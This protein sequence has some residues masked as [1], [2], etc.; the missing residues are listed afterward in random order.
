MAEA[1]SLLE[2]IRFGYGPF[3]GQLFGVGGVDPD[4]VLA[5]LHDQDPAGAAWAQPDLAERFRL[6]TLSKGKKSAANPEKTAAAERL[7]VVYARD[8]LAF[9]ARP[10]ATRLGFPERLVNLWANRLTVANT[11]GVGT[12][13]MPFR[14]GAVRPHVA[15]RF[16]D[17]LKAALWHPAMLLYLNQTA[18][19][20]PNSSLGLRKGR[21]LNENLAR[22]FLELH[23]M[24]TGYDQS[25]VTE[26]ARLMAGMVTDA[27]G[28]RVDPRAAEPGV[29]VILGERY[30]DDDPAAEI[31]RL[32]EFVAARPETARSVG[33]ML[34]RH[35]VADVPPDDLVQAL[36][37]AY[38][39]N[40]GALPPV[41]RVLLTHPDA[42]SNERRK[43]RSPQEFVAAGLRAVNLSGQEKGLPGMHKRGMQLPMVV[44]HMGQP[45]FRAR[46]P[47]GWPE[48]AEGW[49]TPPMMA[50][51]LD[52]A[53]DL[54]RAAGEGSDPSA[55][56]EQVLGDLANPLLHQVVAGAEQR[57]EGLALLLGSPDFMRR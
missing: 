40:D 44:A 5:Q 38:R 10:A 20:G 51:R 53:I 18:S 11:A 25:D 36:A 31:D 22:E 48:V 46:R 35:F 16:A 12:F 14:D 27:R 41:Y 43:L 52:W 7:K 8:T 33:F 1:A 37:A 3:G 57:W 21:G 45:V 26:L 56:A 9:I 30:G 32:V 2:E 6:I 17:M 50:A 23:G 4:R 13:I 42:R 29:K 28:S 15:G 49:L 19:I 54:G 34:A 55:L 47:D 39:A 24:G